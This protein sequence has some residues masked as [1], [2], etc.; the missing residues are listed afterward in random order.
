LHLHTL[1]LLPEPLDLAAT[2]RNL[3]VGATSRKRLK[4]NTSERL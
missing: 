4:L 2:A 3:V 1:G